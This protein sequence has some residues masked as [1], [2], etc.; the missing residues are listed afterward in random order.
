MPTSSVHKTPSPRLYDR[1]LRAALREIPADVLAR[2]AQPK[3]CA[4]L[5]QHGVEMLERDGALRL[6]GW[7]D[8][9]RAPS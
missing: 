8:Q 9:D 3:K 2:I 1:L 7:V 4:V 6:E 5:R